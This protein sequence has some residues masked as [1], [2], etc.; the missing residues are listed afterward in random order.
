MTTTESAQAEKK[1]IREGEV[2][3]VCYS[4]ELINGVGKEVQESADITRW[5]IPGDRHY[6]ETRISKGHVVPNNRPITVV[7][8][9][10][11]REACERLSVEA[12]PPGGLGENLLFEGLGDLSDVQPGDEFHVGLSDGEA[13]VILEAR[14]QNDP[15]SNLMVYHK[16][17]VKEL[18]GKRGILCVVQREGTVRKGDTV[19]LVRPAR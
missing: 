6:G 4:A 8:V 16:Q 11:T 9:E 5:G 10:C 14:K 12:I 13:N 17:M 2:I 15:C 1:V 18:Y 19:K 3:A 7:G